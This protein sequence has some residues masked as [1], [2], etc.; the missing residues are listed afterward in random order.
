MY[1]IS[2][3]TS[4]LSMFYTPKQATVYFQ[5]YDFTHAEVVQLQHDFEK[6]FNPM[7]S[8][9]ISFKILPSMPLPKGCL[10]QA[11]SRYRATKILNWQ[12][13][14][15]SIPYG[16]VVIG[17]THKDISTS[18]HGASDYGILGLAYMG[19][20][21]CIVSDHRVRNKRELWKVAS[22]EFIHAF[23]NY[24]HCPKDD[25][26]CIIKDAKGKENLSRKKQLCPTCNL[27][28]TGN[29]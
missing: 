23:Y 4:I 19:S 27:N 12:R 6:N 22:H 18:A 25:P 17:L 1:V 26:T 14:N 2:F 11:K 9:K 16:G 5:P 28:I 7:V 29:E 13:E 8:T 21:V 20:Q 10:N 24:G 3:I 15:L